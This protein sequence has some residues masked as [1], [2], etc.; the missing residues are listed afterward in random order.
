LHAERARIEIPARDV[1]VEVGDTV[2]VLVHYHIHIVSKIEQVE[3]MS[4]L[5]FR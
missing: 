4:L 3:E 5:F 2:V 1:S